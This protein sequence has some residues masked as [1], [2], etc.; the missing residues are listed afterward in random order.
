MTNLLT[1]GNVTTKYQNGFP[2]E[3]QRFRACAG[4]T[5]TP[6][7][8]RS[9]WSRD[10]FWTNLKLF[11]GFRTHRI[12]GCPPYLRMVEDRCV[13]DILS[14]SSWDPEE[15]LDQDHLSGRVRYLVHG[16]RPVKEQLAEATFDSLG[17]DDV[18]PEVFGPGAPRFGSPKRRVH[19]KNRGKY[20]ASVVAEI[21]TEL[22]LLLT[23]R[24]EENYAVV[25]RKASALMKAHHGLRSVD[26]A[27]FLPLVVEAFFVPSEADIVASDFARSLPVLQRQEEWNA[28]VFDSYL[29]SW[30]P[31]SLFHR[32]NRLPTFRA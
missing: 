2:H 15:Y 14:E 10:P 23:P 22:P 21:R 6:E 8:S 30:W 7:A 9:S 27:R 3:G 18:A 20:I 13:D 16:D 5:L 4:I 31:F 12:V 1:F 32:E 24:S 19:P 17:I 28:R 11:F 29:L 25:A 26:A